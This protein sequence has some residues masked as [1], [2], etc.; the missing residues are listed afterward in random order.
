MAFIIWGSNEHIGK[1]Y[2]ADNFCCPYCD[3]YDS[4]ELFIS[5]NYIDFFFIPYIPTDK[6]GSSLC[7][8]CKRIVKEVNFSR[9]LYDQFKERKKQ[10][11]HPLRMYT[12]LIIL[13]GSIVIAGLIHYI[14]AF[15]TS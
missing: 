4:T 14:H 7:S 12:G 1:S 15:F 3:H 6:S 10:Y 5:S 8:Q 9:K 2:E 11:R 13:P